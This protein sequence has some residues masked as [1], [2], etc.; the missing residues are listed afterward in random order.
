[1]S[2]NITSHLGSA[3]FSPAQTVAKLSDIPTVSSGGRYEPYSVHEVH[4]EGD[5]LASQIAAGY[6]YTISSKLNKNASK[7]EKIAEDNLVTWASAR[8]KWGN[9]TSTWVSNPSVN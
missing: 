8:L 9:V 6:Y 1:M 5:T 4:T 3:V 7:V 2:F